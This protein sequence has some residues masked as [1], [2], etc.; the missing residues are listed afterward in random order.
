MHRSLG[1]VV[2]ALLL[3]VLALPT[4]GA[5]SA[6]AA[7]P[8]QSVFGVN[9][10]IATRYPDLDNLSVP[11]E[12][13][14]QAETGW[15]REDFQIKWIEPQAKTFDWRF[16]DTAIN[17]LAKR[18]IN[19]IGILGGPTP[20]WAT[21][22]NPAND[23]YPP[24]AQSYTQFSSGPSDYGQP[25]PAYAAFSTLIEQLT[26]ATPTGPLSLGQQNV[27]VDFEQF[28]SWRRGTEPNGTFTQSSARPP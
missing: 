6:P 8:G 19:I 21:P 13:L 5:H 23:F 11:V 20:G 4:S 10:H 7:A 3:V 1:L 22:G 12:S 14:A 26:G 17:L 24:D 27:V 28:G 9:S 16:H 15:V 2:V 18:G 25:K